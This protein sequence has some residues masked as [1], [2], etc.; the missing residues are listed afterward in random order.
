MLAVILVAASISIARAD[1]DKSI[2]LENDHYL[3]EFDSTNGAITRILDKASE[4]NLV[5]AP[6]LADNFRLIISIQNGGQ[7]YVQQ[8]IQGKDQTL[9]SSQQTKESLTLWWNGPLRDTQGISHNLRVTFDIKFVKESIEFRLS[10]RNRTQHK[11]AE[12][13]YPLIGG[14]MG[15]GT[16][17]NCTEATLTATTPR[18]WVKRLQKPFGEYAFTYPGHLT[19]SWVDVYNPKLNRGMY[20]ASH[21][22]TGLLRS[23]SFTKATGAAPAKFI[24]NGSRKRSD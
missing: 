4:I 3:L 9:S 11:V 15:F 2:K 6:E 20:F 17:E 19:M 21:N 12:V 14:L 16:P 1:E 23:S 7:D 8:Y 24:A 18:P 10:V 13:W 22:L 5:P